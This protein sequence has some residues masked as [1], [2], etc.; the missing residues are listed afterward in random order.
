MKALV[1]EK[2]LKELAVRESFL[3]IPISRQKLTLTTHRVRSEGSRLGTTRVDSIML[4]A[5]DS[6][7]TVRRNLPVLLILG[8]LCLFAGSA[9]TFATNLGLPPL[10]YGMTWTLIWFILYFASK[11]RVLRV[12]SA[13]CGI[14]VPITGSSRMEEVTAFL[15]F[16]EA[17]KNARYLSHANAPAEH[18]S[19]VTSTQ[20]KP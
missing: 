11:M 6:C 18:A 12:S 20:T 8:V 5:V 7:G 14:V 15:D 2:S 3:F 10:L 19:R 17:A 9:L 16:L 4:E 13:A 1:N